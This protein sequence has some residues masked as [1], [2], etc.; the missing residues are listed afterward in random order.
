MEN[1]I[2]FGVKNKNIKAKKMN[3]VFLSVLRTSDLP[4]R[5]SFLDNQVT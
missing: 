2:K 1:K 4:L 3:W 5:K